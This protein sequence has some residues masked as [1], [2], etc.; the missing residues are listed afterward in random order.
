MLEK[1]TEE[2]YIVKITYNN[3]PYA[4]I[5]DFNPVFYICGTDTWCE[6]H[7]LIDA[8]QFSNIKNARSSINT[9]IRYGRLK[10][11]DCEILKAKFTVEELEVV[12]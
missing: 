6:T 11:C 1:K 9:R 2:S 7:N 4:N 3:P 10:N 5:G 12:G 8:R